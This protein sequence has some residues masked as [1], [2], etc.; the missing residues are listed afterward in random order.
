MD[1]TGYVLA[2]W[3]YAN[4]YMHAIMVGGKEVMDLKERWEGNLGE[5]RRVKSN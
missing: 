5:R 1:S 3:V 2:I 4:T